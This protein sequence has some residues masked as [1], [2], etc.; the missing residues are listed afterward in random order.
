MG[1]S[2]GR[3][4]AG[5]SFLRRIVL[6]RL[7]SA[8]TLITVLGSPC[9]T[10]HAQPGPDYILIGEDADSYYYMKKSEYT[11]SAAEKTSQKYHQLKL[12]LGAD[13]AAIREQGFAVV[14]ERWELYAGVAKEEKEALQ[15][16]LFN[17]LLDQ[18]LDATTLAAESAK[19][20]NPWNVNKAID[21]LKEK[22]FRNE[23]VLAALRK[24][25]RTSGKPEMAEAY[26]EFVEA[27]KAAKEGWNTG[28]DMKKDPENAQLRL[29]V[30]AL[31]CLQGN[32]EL[33][34]V[35]TGAEFGEHLLYLGYLTGKVGEL[36][37]VTDEKLSTLAVLTERLKG[38]VSE[39]NEAK[40]A[41]R[42][43][44]GYGTATPVSGPEAGR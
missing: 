7:F 31:K 11:G 23:A 1:G 13:Q 37:R 36:A 16:D 33:G 3:C 14:G 27:F 17:A 10:A 34:L 18:A 15:R 32:P 9:R 39:L 4:G 24:I 41:W 8:A 44:T 22:G 29:A 19:S 5:K 2:W 42:K 26:K 21:L 43:A 40:K 38:H 25:A 28:K 6:P 12:V 30:G 35:V 20:L